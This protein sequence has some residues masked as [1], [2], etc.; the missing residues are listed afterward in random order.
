MK[1]YYISARTQFGENGYIY[2]DSTGRRI[3]EGM[4]QA[5]K[6]DL[7]TRVSNCIVAKAMDSGC[8]V[9][10]THSTVIVSFKKGSANG[11]D[12]KD[13]V[14]SDGYDPNSLVSATQYG[15]TIRYEFEKQYAL[16]R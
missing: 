4:Q 5:S 11:Q 8:P 14:E 15:D 13:R 10:S 6:F 9:R 12:F 7:E 3:Y 1:T 2:T 16:G